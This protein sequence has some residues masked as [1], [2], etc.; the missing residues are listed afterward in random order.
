[1]SSLPMACSQL[2]RGQTP[3]LTSD[4]IEN[5]ENFRKT[6]AVPSLQTSCPLKPR[7]HSYPRLRLPS[8]LVEEA[9]W[10]GR[11]LVSGSNQR[12]GVP[13]ALALSI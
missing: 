5:S 12:H 13:V 3:S 1:M 8:A 7:S 6:A 10:R 9:E 4:R 11:R 2:T